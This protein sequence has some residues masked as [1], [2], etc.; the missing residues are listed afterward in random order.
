MGQSK[1]FPK[2]AT[3]DTMTTKPGKT[4]RCPICKADTVHAFR[5]FCSSPCADA[6]L[7]NWLTGSYKIAVD[8][9]SSSEDDGSDAQ[10]SRTPPPRKP[11]D[12]DD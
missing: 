8:D 3:K 5:P 11:A 6:D 7:G 10:A 4:G 9:S 12:D 2:G 1:P